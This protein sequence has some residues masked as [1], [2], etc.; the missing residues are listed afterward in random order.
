MVNT[1]DARQAADVQWNAA[2]IGQTLPT[3]GEVLTYTESQARVDFTSGA[4]VRIGP[5]TH[6]TVA[7][8][9]GPA[10]D[11]V[12]RLTLL[13]GEAWAVLTASL[14]NGSFEIETPVGSASVRGSYL[15]VAYDPG[16][17]SLI[18]SCLEG[19]CRVR[20]ALGQVDLIAGQE[21]SILSLNQL[22]DLPRPLA[23]ERL[24][25]WRQFVREAEPHIEPMRL[26]LEPV[27]SATRDALQTQIATLTPEPGFLLTLAASR[28]PLAPRI[29]VQPGG[30]RP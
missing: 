27:W 14:N 18:A 6:F 11:P 30:I 8:L 29:T 13:A 23:L 2:A 7:E 22:P 1:V 24:E 16:T 28:T 20:N 25:R 17:Q 4:I 10:T 21:T 9:S 15:S 3:G 26:Q 12:T 5:E 19:S